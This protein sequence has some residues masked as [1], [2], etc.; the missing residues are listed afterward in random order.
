M[1]IYEGIISQKGGIADGWALSYFLH[2]DLAFFPARAILRVSDL[3]NQRARVLDNVFFDFRSAQSPYNIQVPDEKKWSSRMRSEVV[4]DLKLVA[5]LMAGVYNEITV[6]MDLSWYP[7]H[8]SIAW[9]GEKSF[10]RMTTRSPP[11]TAI[12]GEIDFDSD[13]LR[14]FGPCNSAYR[15]KKADFETA[16]A[17]NPAKDGRPRPPLV[18]LSKPS[19][20]TSMSS[21]HA[22]DSLPEDD[23]TES[24]EHDR[25]TE[26][27]KEG[28]HPDETSDRKPVP[29]IE[30]DMLDHAPK[31]KTTGNQSSSAKF[32]NPPPP[33]PKDE[34]TSSDPE[35]KVDDSQA[36][37]KKSDLTS[38]QGETEISTT[39][40]DKPVVLG[41]ERPPA[42]PPLI[43]EVEP[44]LPCSIRPPP[45]FTQIT[46]T[47]KGKFA[48]TAGQPGK[49]KSTV[50]TP[51]PMAQLQNTLGIPPANE[52]E[53][54][55]RQLRAQQLGG[56]HPAMYNWLVFGKAPSPVISSTNQISQIESLSET[57]G[58]L[59]LNEPD[60]EGQNP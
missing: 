25:D 1:Y 30:Q 46:S 37:A 29:I 26:P 14:R 53:L 7:G 40:P 38:P 42:Q 43:T 60:R 19:P 54:F 2:M 31:T 41:P 34:S 36:E 20:R 44:K 4:G 39:A 45:S 23:E 28:D 22:D 8:I 17:N 56:L 15:S 5:P 11:S 33:P 50:F 18:P 16:H 51:D 55:E 12:W 24:S 49:G 10:V 58:S 32:K 52:S 35:V 57:S 13:L 21:D 59:A 27:E 9:Y 6:E 3:G 48:I 47:P